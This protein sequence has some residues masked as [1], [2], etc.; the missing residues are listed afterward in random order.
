MGLGRKITEVKCPDQPIQW[1]GQLLSTWHVPCDAGVARLAEV[2]LV[3]SLHCGFLFLLTCYSVL[4]G[5]HICS[6]STAWCYR[7]HWL[8]DCVV[9]S[10]KCSLL[11]PHVLSVAG[12][13]SGV[14]RGAPHTSPGIMCPGC[15]QVPTPQT[16]AEKGAH[17][18][19]PWTRN[20]GASC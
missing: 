17:C 10:V 2:V 6:C 19:L 14:L 11:L 4:L 8:P 15:S 12:A 3:G 7:C 18:G 20:Q 9:S 1:G 13:C 5:A 16:A